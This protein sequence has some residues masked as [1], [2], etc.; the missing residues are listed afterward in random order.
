[1]ACAADGGRILLFH[2][3]NEKLWKVAE[4]GER[5]Q[6]LAIPAVTPEGSHE[7]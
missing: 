7:R 3:Q 1:V 2:P 6:Q 4:E 5:M